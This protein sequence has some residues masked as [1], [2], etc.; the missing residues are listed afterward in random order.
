MTSDPHPQVSTAD[1]LATAGPPPVRPARAGINR[2]LRCGVRRTGRPTRTRRYQPQGTSPFT[3]S[4]QSDLHAQVSTGVVVFRGEQAQ[5]RPA[6]VGMNRT[7]PFSSTATSC[8]TR[9][10]R[11]QPPPGTEGNPS[12]WPDPHTQ[13]STGVAAGVV[14]VPEARPARAGIDRRMSVPGL[15]NSSPTRTRRYQPRDEASQRLDMVSDPHAQVSTAGR[16]HCQVQRAV[17]P[18][19]RY[20]PSTV[21]RY[22]T[23]QESDPHAQV[24][25]GGVDVL[26]RQVSVRPVRAG[27][28]RSGRCGSRRWSGPTRTRRYQPTMTCRSPGIT[29]PDPHAQVLTG[30]RPAEAR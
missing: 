3:P 21:A 24:S 25:T 26:A 4:P 11:Y 29:L 6:H 5:A 20:Q 22:E 30:L 27:I 19:R 13:V 10:C 7:F 8:P 12:Q 1:Q 9:T 18:T 17:R 2:G 23:W 28:D 16:P 15:E 14:A